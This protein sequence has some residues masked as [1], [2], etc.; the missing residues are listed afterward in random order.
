MVEASTLV[1]DIV[2][3]LASLRLKVNEQSRLLAVS[4]TK[5]M[6]DILAAYE[7]GQRHFGENYVDEF[8]EKMSLDSPADIKW[9]FIG[10]I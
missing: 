4:K 5:P 6:S 1:D 8:A 7:A 2:N 9:H 3:N 10:H